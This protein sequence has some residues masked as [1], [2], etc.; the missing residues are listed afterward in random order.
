MLFH[1]WPFLAFLLVVLP[2]FFALRKTPLWIPWLGLASY[3][4]YGWGDPYYLILVV[5]STMLDYTLVA[6]MDHCPP[7]PLGEKR[8]NR[9]RFDDRILLIAFIVATILTLTCVTM[10]FAGPPTL[11]PTMTLFIL[12]CFLM[13][14]GAFLR[15]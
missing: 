5:Y 12:I 3:F 9:F 8:P 4:F 6:L 1:T 14:L 7:T 15:S 2:V 11:R 10:A 13:A